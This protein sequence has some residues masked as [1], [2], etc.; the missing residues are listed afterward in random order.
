MPAKLL[1]WFIAA[2]KIKIISKNI[3]ISDEHSQ[4]IL[5]LIDNIDELRIWIHIVNLGIQV[6]SVG[7]S[8]EGPSRQKK[9][10]KRNSKE[11]NKLFQ[12]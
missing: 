5:D 4:E 7:I 10:T 3:V 12:E 2:I 11:I 1:V 8:W 9:K 6:E